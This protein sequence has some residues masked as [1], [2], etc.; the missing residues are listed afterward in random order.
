MLRFILTFMVL[1]VGVVGC[2]FESLT[3][4][5]AA[6]SAEAEGFDGPED[7]DSVKVRHG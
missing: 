2:A 5:D 1:V 7:L 3:F 4:P 6:D